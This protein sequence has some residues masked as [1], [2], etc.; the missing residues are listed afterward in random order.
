V[1]E[2]KSQG[3]EAGKGRRQGKWA[4]HWEKAIWDRRL[5]SVLFLVGLTAVFLV[6]HTTT[7]PVGTLYEPGE[8]VQRNV[9]AP[10]AF[11]FL[12]EARTEAER[13][14][15][16]DSV[17]PLFDFNSRAGRERLTDLRAS[18]Q[19]ARQAT[20]EFFASVY[21][22]PR[23]DQT[24][25]PPYPL[26]PPQRVQEALEGA[27]PQ[28]DDALRH[29]LYRHGASVA[30]ENWIVLAVETMQR[31]KIVSSSEGLAELDK[32]LVRDI[33]TGAEWEVAKPTSAISIEDARAQIT[34]RDEEIEGDDLT[35]AERAAV[36]TFAA[37]LVRPTLS[38]NVKETETRRNRAAEKVAP[39]VEV[40][41]KGKIIVREGEEVS[42]YQAALLKSLAARTKST[43][44]WRNVL[45]YAGLAAILVAFLW[46]YLDRDRTR[47]SLQRKPLFAMVVLT[48]LC[49]VAVSALFL[50]L[51]D[52]LTEYLKGPWALT[53]DTLRFA[54][55]WAA[56]AMVL[57][58]LSDRQVAVA[59]SVVYSLLMGLYLAGNYPLTLFCLLSCLGGAFAVRR[60]KKRSEP[61]KASLFVGLINLGLVLLLHTLSPWLSGGR[62][63]WWDYLAALAGG[64]SVLVVFHLLFPLMEHAFGIL[65]DVRLLELGDPDNPLLREMAIR[66]PGTYQ[67]SVAVG[68]LSE[69]AAESIGANA[70]F[71]RV[72]ALYHDVGKM[73]KP[74]YFIENL[75]GEVNPHERLSP[76]MSTLI[77]ISH[78]KDGL[79][80]TRKAG[81]PSPIRD[82]IPQHHGTRLIAYF[83]KKAGEENE[84]E[85]RYPGP[86]PQTK[87][88]AISM[89]SDAVEAAARTLR[90]PTSARLKGMIRQVTN[91]IMLDG[92]LDQCDLNFKEIEQIQDAL[93]KIL[94]SMYHGRIDYPGY[95]F[96]KKRERRRDP[97]VVSFRPQNGS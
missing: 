51:A 47:Y 33:H 52:V 76:H 44:N 88:A 84:E 80:M 55:P 2:P 93:L 75:R 94:L 79:K 40:V 35:A 30:L 43:T 95:E 97:K 13:R 7:R 58:L 9:K 21:G 64:A 8:I 49:S 50:F 62:W 82:I 16:R 91:S 71:C 28:M 77:I 20:D 5:W 63:S 53:Q 26:P 32:I 25:G 86:K 66:A 11:E 69:A 10:F 87:E 37:S 72:G 42:P 68:R 15:A 83:F 67:H 70:L 60:F 45:G 1:A 3:R 46:F 61:F 96:E 24:A 65:T 57:A 81:V 18:F 23:P 39:V 14:V 17:P 12:D 31:G 54:V 90:N 38:P 19:Q 34:T 4:L 41:P 78:V 6:K 73:R 85:F 56:G 22:P 48:T 59:Y 89:I 92:Q 27:F 36:A 74:E 29:A